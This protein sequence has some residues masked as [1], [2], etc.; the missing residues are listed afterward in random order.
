MAFQ[1]VFRNRSVFVTGHTGFK[2]SWLCLWLARMGARVTGYALAP[3]TDPNNFEV[4]RVSTVLEGHHFGDIRDSQRMTA[5]MRKADPDLVLHLAAETVVRRGYEIPRETFDVNVIGTASVLDSVRA[6]DRPCAVIAV[7]S[8]KCYENRDLVWGYREED[9]MGE[10]DP[11]GASKGAAEIL[12]R[13]YRCSFFPPEKLASHGVKL[14]SVRAGN[15]IG[16]GDWTRDALFTDMVRSLAANEPIAVRNPNASRPWQHVL[17]ALDGYLSVAAKLLTSDDPQFCSGWNIGPLPGAE[18]S[19]RGIVELFIDVWGNGSWRDASDVNAP[20]EA[21]TLRLN[22]DKAIWQLGWQPRWSLMEALHRTADW[23]RQYY[24]DDSD[25][26]QVCLDQIASYESAPQ[27]NPGRGDQSKPQTATN[28]TS[29]LKR[30]AL[31]S[32]N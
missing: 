31:T 27:P 6:L 28:G 7:T 14:A 32:N 1:D 17:Q 3:P 10:H 5:A 23:Y 20:R 11:Y 26:Q 2:G 15:V 19:V 21:N 18:L 30:S 4:S 24:Q 22:I 12:I 29:H 8:D 16:G 25:M 9:P 13:A